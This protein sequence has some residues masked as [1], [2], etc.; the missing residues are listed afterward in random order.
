[1]KICFDKQKDIN[2]YWYSRPINN[3]LLNG[4][5]IKEWDKSSN[6]GYAKYL[7]RDRPSNRAI[8][9]HNLGGFEHFDSYHECEKDLIAKIK[10]FAK[11]ILK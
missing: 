10:H 11:E 7:E 9:T 6:G 8:W 2:G 5:E 3:P 1:M 4:L